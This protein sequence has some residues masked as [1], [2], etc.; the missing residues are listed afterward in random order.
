LGQFG[1]VTLTAEQEEVVQYTFTDI[2]PVPAEP[3][4]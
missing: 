2:Q 4:E 1:E 3:G